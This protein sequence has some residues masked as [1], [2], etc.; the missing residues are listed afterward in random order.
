LDLVL[1][2]V[3]A[4]RLEFALIQFAAGDEVT[5][6]HTN[7]KAITP[8]PITVENYLVHMA[9]NHKVIKRIYMSDIKTSS[10][11]ARAAFAISHGP[12]CPCGGCANMRILF[13]TPQGAAT[14]TLLHADSIAAIP[15]S[16]QCRARILGISDS[17]NSAL[18]HHFIAEYGESNGLALDAVFISKLGRVSQNQRTRIVRALNSEAK[19]TL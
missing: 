4:S 10:T 19:N 15:T 7:A 6:I 9:L 2:A 8:L 1:L 18:V 5:K 11:T 13:T 14:A 16:V 17:A 3:S 12:A